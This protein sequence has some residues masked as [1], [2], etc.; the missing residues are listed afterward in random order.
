[1]F[2]N[3]ISLTLSQQLLKNYNYEFLFR[4]NSRLA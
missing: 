4:F 2:C 1:M 3:Q